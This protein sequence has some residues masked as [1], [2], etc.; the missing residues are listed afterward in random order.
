MRSDA[1][2]PMEL[3]LGRLVKPMCS[4]IWVSGREVK[5][6]EDNSIFS[7]WPEL[8]DLVTLSVD[9]K[10]RSVSYT[11]T[12]DTTTVSRLIAWYRALY[13]DFDADWEQEARRLLVQGSV[14]RTA[15]YV[16]DQG[17][18]ILPL[19]GS[20]LKFTPV[21]VKTTLPDAVT[22]DWPMG[23]RLPH[24]ASTLDPVR[25]QEAVDAAFANPDSCTAAF[26]VLYHGQIVG[27][28]YAPGIDLHTQL[29][30]WSMG[31]SLTATLLG[32]LLQQGLFHLE[33]PAPVP[34]WHRPGDPRGAIR[35]ID[36]LR[37]SSGLKFTRD[38]PRHTWEHSIPDHFLVYADAIDVFD[39]SINRP[40]EYPPN[41]VGRY[42]NC[43]PLTLGYIIK[44]TVTEQLGEEYLTW[45][46]RALFDR[47]G[48]RRQ[49]LET[50]VYGNFILTGYD[51][52]TARNWARLGLLYAQDGVWNGERLLPAGYAK[53]VGTPA[54]AWEEPEYG[55]QFWVNGTGK[56]P[57]PRDAYYMAGFCEQRV[58]I[59]PSHDL[60]VVRLGHR[61]GSEPGK[62]DLDNALRRLIAAVETAR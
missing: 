34:A 15:Q 29:E 54:P 7:E 12:L 32:I 49:V 39:F 56:Y 26:L 52:G 41:T 2:I 38:E 10:H 36:L 55:G 57:I 9:W 22:Q 33:D 44:R 27:E 5:E 30:S 4:A 60:V 51:F 61:R 53:L 25:V 16:G 40:L 37:M 3:I 13:P 35:I 47:L 20:G 23:D 50:D 8:R 24:I 18:I 17:C 31:K 46:Q 62:V 6:A 11:V 1:I 45:P 14:T 59:I 42:R 48:I 21:E 58:F 19:D 28:R 43:D